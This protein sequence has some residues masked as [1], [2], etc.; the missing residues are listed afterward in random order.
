MHKIANWGL[1][2][3]I[4]CPLSCFAVGLSGIHIHSALNQPFSA[5]LDL[6]GLRGM[7][8]AD[9]EVKVANYKTYQQMGLD[10][11]YQLSKLSFDVTRDSRGKPVV[12][13][14]STDRITEP[15]L[16]LV[17]DV[18]W[19]DGG[20]VRSYTVLLDP[21]HYTSAAGSTV[22]KSHHYAK[23]SAQPSTPVAVAQPKVIAKPTIASS[24]TVKPNQTLLG[25]ALQIKPSGAV[26]LDQT[27][28][29]I[30]GAN[31]KAFLR[32]NVNLLKSGR[33]LQIPSEQVIKS[34]PALK[35]DQEIHA[36]NYSW[37]HHQATQHV[38]KQPY[39]INPTA[40]K[41]APEPKNIEPNSR[42]MPLVTH[43]APLLEQMAVSSKTPTT[44]QT[45][46]LR[47]EL[48]ASVSQSQQLQQQVQQLQQQNHVLQSLISDKLTELDAAAQQLLKLQQAKMPAGFAPSKPKTVAQRQAVAGQNALLQQDNGG[49]WLSKLLMS[50]LIL[51]ASF[52]AWFIYRR[53]FF[54]TEGLASY[55]VSPPPP[56]PKEVFTRTDITPSHRTDL[57]PR[58][59]PDVQPDVQTAEQPDVQP[60]PEDTH[61]IDFY[62][63]DDNAEPSVDS[64][65]NEMDDGLA[66]VSPDVDI[67]STKLE[68]AR[69][70]LKMGDKSGAIKLIEEII[71][72]GTTEQR[73]LAEQLLSKI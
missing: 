1:A 22:N 60:E 36:Q 5:E 46:V 55:E 45:T 7:P 43:T 38:L 3:G 10:K 59:E 25:I 63:E 28:L 47:A 31:P 71:Y 48:S 6:L 42:V 66:S 53:K 2:L 54:V 8:L 50:V 17:L 64:V 73:Q 23:Q 26:S 19:P 27:M 70:Y 11:S 44:D 51:A 30:E 61:T 12:V 58:F 68:L 35:A 24:W 16:Q 37:A 4:C 18:K 52:G 67:N 14:S 33:H 13:V 39:F 34:I 15:Y 32:G 21:A 65:S 20:L 56:A 40:P 57:P 29:A 69:A 49:G 9:V 62:P 72:E 41:P